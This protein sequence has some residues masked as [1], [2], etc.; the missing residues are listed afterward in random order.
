MLLNGCERGLYA[1]ILGLVGNFADADD[2]DQIV[3]LQLWREFGKYEPGTDFGAWARTLARYQ[4]MAHFSSKKRSR[5]QYAS[6]VIK[7]LADDL[8]VEAEQ[9]DRR[10]YALEECLK[11]V[12][13]S[14]RDLLRR[15]YTDGAAVNQVARD[16]GRPVDQLYKILSRT[17]RFLHDCIQKRICQGDTA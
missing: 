12:S 13:D 5:A 3:K 8:A 11:S 9:F 16:S 17:R 1:Y 10:A 6:E 2:L 4:V 7:L 15:V 14:N